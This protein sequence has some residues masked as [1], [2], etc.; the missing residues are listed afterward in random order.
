MP[1]TPI[2]SSDIQRLIA[3]GEDWESLVPAAVAEYIAEHGL[4]GA[5][6]GFTTEG[7]EGTEGMKN[8]E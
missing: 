4:Y 8:D 2:S 7:T 6:V 5:G 3:A 1:P